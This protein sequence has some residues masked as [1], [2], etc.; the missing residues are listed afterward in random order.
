M[1]L[2]KSKKHIAIP[3]KQCW[4]TYQ[5]RL[6][7]SAVKKRLGRLTLR[8]CTVVFVFLVFG[9]SGFLHPDVASLLTGS[10]FGSGAPGEKAAASA[11][12]IGKKEVRD[13]LKNRTLV[14]MKEKSF[15]VVSEG[16]RYRVDTSLDVAL[17]NFLLG[18]LNAST[19]RYIAIVCMD[20]MT[21]RVLSMVGFDKNDPSNNPCIDNR[22]PAAS[23]FKIITAS[24]AVEKFGLNSDS[25]FTFNGKKHT[26]YKSQ[27]K[28][29]TNRF[30]NRITLEDSFAQ[31]VNPVFGKIGVHYLGKSALENY[32][33]AFGF[34]R[35]IDFELDLEPSLISI[36][37]NPYQWA[38]IACGFNRETKISP[39][40]GALMTAA[41]LNR[42]RLMEPT[43]VDR[44]L[45]ENGR[46]LYRSRQVFLNRAVSPE[47]SE[48]VNKLME[49]TIDSG[50]CRKAFRGL[51]KD[52]ILSRLNIGAKSGSIDNRAHDTRYDWFVGF[53]EDK[54]GAG[55]IVI[56][57]IVAH[58]KYI[59]T[60]ASH[61][62]RIAIKQYFRN[63]FAAKNNNLEK[64]IKNARL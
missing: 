37:D 29:R 9:F 36:E 53:A 64:E 47:A 20:P 58:E 23:I 13:L 30:T 7:R 35:N 33:E 19:S 41:L 54:A 4:Q 51:R 48:V 27:L 49:N 60:R 40:H 17:Q 3:E 5:E 12:R 43:I 38:E 11:K 26:L 55:K 10:N 25:E 46:L 56:S 59:G 31:S 50:T 14:N 32:A 28:D 22:F 21:G 61:Y 18:R 34:N 2:E 45:D 42:G 8:T 57:A 6:K 39:L 52:K 24:A 63:Y 44:V 15:E 62:A 16:S 1:E